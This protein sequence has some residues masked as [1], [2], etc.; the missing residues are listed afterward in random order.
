M[1]IKEINFSEKFKFFA[2]DKVKLISILLDKIKGP[3][4]K[5]KI[6]SV[7]C[8]TAEELEVLHNYGDVYAIDIDKE[9][10]KFAKVC[11]EVKIC[12]VC[13]LDYPDEFFDIICAFDV[14]E[15]IE[16]DEKAVKQIYRV[17]SKNGVFIF[18]VPAF[19]F[20][21]SSHDKFLG[22]KKRYDKKMLKNLL[23]RFSKLDLFFYSYILFVPMMLFRILRKKAEESSDFEVTPKFILVFQHIISQIELFLLKLNFK[24]N[25]FGLTICGIAYKNG[26]EIT[27]Y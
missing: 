11:K 12:D 18:T 1:D 14:L 26:Y 2:K 13:E 5:Y 25:I 24:F 16:D 17:L 7:G 22:H 8:G 6:L 3:D 27:K 21:F 10:L 20:I 4:N 15:H 19:N 9:V 23:Q